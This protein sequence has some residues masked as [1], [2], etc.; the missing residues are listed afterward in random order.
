MALLS[1]ET[2]EE[3]EALTEILLQDGHPSSPA[4]HYWMSGSDQ[5]QEGFWYW[6]D[7]KRK[8]FTYTNWCPGEPNNLN[9]RNATIEH[10]L[11]KVHPK[12]EKSSCWNDMDKGSSDYNQYWSRTYAICESSL[13]AI[14]Y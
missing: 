11:V 7:D 13:I 1:V 4:I 6:D 9:P 12:T 8:P 5:G 14:R 10:Y 2:K 3:E